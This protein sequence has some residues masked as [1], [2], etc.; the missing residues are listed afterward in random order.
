MPPIVPDAFAP[1]TVVATPEIT[2]SAAST[3]GDL[4]FDKP[5][6]AATTFAPG[7]ATFRYELLDPKGATPERSYR[8]YS[9]GADGQ[10][11]K[12]APADPPHM[13]L[14]NEPGTDYVINRRD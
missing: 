10:D 11:N 13:A 3:L 1:V 12:G 6:I 8:L 9:V 7:G 14:T 4:V 5:G 2:R